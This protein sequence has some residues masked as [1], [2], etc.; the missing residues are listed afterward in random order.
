[1]IHE[2]RHDQNII[3]KYKKMKDINACQKNN[4]A[5]QTSTSIRNAFVQEFVN[6]TCRHVT[7]YHETVINPVFT[8]PLVGLN[9]KLS[10]TIICTL[11]E[12]FSS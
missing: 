5:T 2:E 9:L 7:Y 10:T 1:M 12:Y 3:L 11:S 6:L 8:F 4:S